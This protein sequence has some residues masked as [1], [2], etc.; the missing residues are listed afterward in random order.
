M[1][2]LSRSRY[3]QE[4]ICQIFSHCCKVRTRV[5]VLTVNLCVFLYQRADCWSLTLTWF[6]FWL[7]LLYLGVNVLFD[8]LALYRFY[9]LQ[10]CM[11]VSLL[12]ALTF[13][14]KR[15]A[16]K[17]LSSIKSSCQE[18]S[19][20]LQGAK[21]SLP[22]GKSAER[23][24]PCTVLQS[25]PCTQCLKNPISVLLKKGSNLHWKVLFILL[26][27]LNSLLGNHGWLFIWSVWQFLN[28]F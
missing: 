20:L 19:M 17:L 13:S 9:W 23:V 25:P 5:N 3:T 24:A 27:I 16:C 7:W 28:T 10:Y 1:A 22:R 14:L 15:S 12:S 18:V 11:L 21:V 2:L 8:I 4:Y 6:A 26:H